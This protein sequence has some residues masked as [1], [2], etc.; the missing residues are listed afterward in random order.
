[1]KIYPNNQH[2]PFCDICHEPGEY[3]QDMEI[4]STENGEY[5]GIAHY[6]QCFDRLKEKH[7]PLSSVST[8]I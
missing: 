2:K 7:R 8:N 6:G 1:M 4:L 5:C 3:Q